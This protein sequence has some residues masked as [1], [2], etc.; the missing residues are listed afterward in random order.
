[1]K[2]ILI[3]NGSIINRNNIINSDILINGPFIERVDKNI[4]DAN[5][6]IIDATG[7]LVFPGIIDDQVH[8]REP[9]LTHKADIFTE[10][11]AAVA[12][13]ITSFMEMPNTVPNATTQELLADKYKIASERSLANYSF[14]MG[15]TNN[16][17]DEIL[18]T[19]PTA[20]CGVKIFMGS[21]TGNMLVDSIKAL[22]DIFTKSPLLIATH[23]E[24]EKTI[25][26]NIQKY[27]AM[28]G[29]DV[30]VKFHPDIRSTEA[31]YKSSS[32]AVSLAKKNGSRL[33]VLHISSAM[34]LSLFNQEKVEHKR[35][36][37]EACVHHL[38]FHKK[39]YDK[40]G[41][42][43]KWNPAIKHINDRNAI[44]DAVND[45]RIDIIAT[46][47]APHTLEEKRNTYFKAPSGGPLI[48]HSL[49]V[50]M[51]LYH[52]G[53][54]DLMCIAQ[55]MAHNP[56]I[57]YQIDRRGFLDEGYFADIT[58]VDPDKP[59]EVT[60]QNIRSKCGWSPFENTQFKSSIY[61]TIISG[62]L[63][64]DQGHILEKGSGDR[65]L[66]NR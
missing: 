66:F 20:V 11:R 41:T 42:L 47:H 19:D 50:M 65:L 13:G 48:Q 25:Q 38:W 27:R 14:Y 56:A 5:A 49:L 29:E 18:K 58:I 3:V 23:C 6:D 2:R 39:D 37:A 10:S 35:I 61:K 46:D 8:F 60:K 55:K 54:F 1:M 24:D 53:I 40:K 64:Y 45:N 51:E 9:G 33:H 4:S 34:E 36:T 43:I 52:Q 31:C 17:L 12:G 57:I 21:S 28:Y 26:E 63:A 16:N 59:F 22:E 32:L 7:K 44:R 62:K 15:A 30:P